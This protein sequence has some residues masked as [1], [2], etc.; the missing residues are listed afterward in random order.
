MRWMK[1]HFGPTIHY[2]FQ[3][4]VHVFCLS[5]AASVL[6]S[7]FPFLIVMVSLCKF[8][9]HWQGAVDAI[10]FALR[11]TFPGEWSEWII[12]NLNVIVVKRGPFQYGSMLLLF[13]AANGVFEPLEVALNKVWGVRTN[14]SYFRNQLLSLGFIFTC[15]GLILLSMILTAI[16]REAIGKPLSDPTALTI[17]TVVFRTAAV[18]VSIL[19]IF[20]IYWVLPN[21]KILWKRVL[22]VAIFS[23]IS[24]EG[25]KYLTLLFWERVDEKFYLEYGPF[26][27]AAIMVLWSFLASML[28]L[29]GA[30]WAA[31]HGFEMKLS[32]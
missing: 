12:R 15:G 20:L 19:V 28:I 9:L 6:L 25:L 22:P 4:E 24:L 5:I 13:F 3:T 32:P 11:D 7:F 14:R 30:E 31:R 8:M 27:Y 26:E 17:T 21:T 2:W 16:N 10:Y 18:L 1:R 23:G 29:G